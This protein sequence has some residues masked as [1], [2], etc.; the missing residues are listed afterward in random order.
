MKKKNTS[1]QAEIWDVAHM[2]EIVV[3]LDSKFSFSTS[4]ARSKTPQLHD[5]LIECNSLCQF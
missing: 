4:S 5:A 2:T 1:L 3:E